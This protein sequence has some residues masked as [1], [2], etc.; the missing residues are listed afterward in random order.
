VSFANASGSVI[1][2]LQAGT[3][4]GADGSDTLRNFN[5]IRASNFDDI[6]LGTNRNDGVTEHFEGLAGNDTIDGRGGFDA[7][8]YDWTGSAVNVNLATGTASDG[9]GYTDT[10]LNIEGVRGSKYND[11]LTGGNAANGT[12]V[13]DYLNNQIEFFSGNAGNDTINGGAGYN[14][15]QYLGSEYDYIVTRLD[16][17]SFTV[18]AKANTP[19]ESDIAPIAMGGRTEEVAERNP[20]TDARTI[21][22]ICI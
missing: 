22:G 16:D 2:D 21:A 17:G 14:L 6:L 9:Y 20:V 1:V 15:A 4:T 12:S 10:L 13:F 8:R 5:Q 7:V 11:V 19:T 18:R 3:A